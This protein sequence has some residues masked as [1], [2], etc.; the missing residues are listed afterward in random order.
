MELVYLG[1][2]IADMLLEHG[3]DINARDSDGETP[4]MRAIEFGKLTK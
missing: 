1:S 3:A 4:L 2:V